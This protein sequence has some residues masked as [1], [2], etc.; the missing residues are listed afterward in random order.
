MVLSSLFRGY[1]QSVADTIPDPVKA[2]A[3][4][5]SANM[6]VKKVTPRASPELSARNTSLPGQ[7]MLKAK[8]VP[9]SVSYYWEYSPDEVSWTAVPE[10][11]QANT[12]IS[13]LSSA[14]YHS[15]RFRTLT[16]KGK[17][18]YSQVVRLLVA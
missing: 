13:G 8:R 14:K 16:P 7:V 6:S 1:V 10:T 2:A 11:T 5:A 3:V 18:D 17:S 15:F 4:I 9:K 12:T